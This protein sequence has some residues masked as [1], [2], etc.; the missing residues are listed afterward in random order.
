MRLRSSRT[1]W[2]GDRRGRLLAAA[3]VTAVIAYVGWKIGESPSQALQFGF[4]GLSVGAIYALLA[5]GFTIVYSTVWFFDLYYGASAAIGAYGVFYLRSKD[6]LSGLHSVHNAYV[7][8]LFASVVAGVVAW[9]LYE[10]LYRRLSHRYN[11]EVLLAA[12]GIVSAA[13]GCYTLAVLH[14]TE[15]LNVVLSPA[16]GCAAALA[17]AWLVFKGLERVVGGAGRRIVVGVAAVMGLAVGAF[18]ALYVVGEPGTRLYLSWVL[19]CLLA[20]VVG[21]A[22][23]RGLYAHMRERARSPLVMLVATLGILLA[24]S[25]AIVLVFGSPARPLPDV[26]GSQPREIW[27][28]TI[29]DFN[30]FT[31]GVAIVAFLGLLF[32]LKRTSLGRA[33]RAIGDDEEVSKVVGI[34]TTVVI[35]I[36]FFIGAVYAAL[37]GVLSGHD[38]AIQPRM[39]LLLL[40]KGWIASVVGGI[41]NLYGAAIGGLA[42]GMVEQFGIWDL[43]GEWRDVI[44]F[45]LL[46]L[47]LSFWPRGLLPRR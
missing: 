46:I 34:N 15:N 35:S 47:F 3:L 38:T 42:L 26:F 28:G 8:V 25:A 31:V 21:L 27:G 19:S 1:F 43:A 39:G 12:G 11:R 23:Y 16:V 29:K 13:A 9:I 41:G 33:I 44:S 40:L 5:M 4:N 30:L 18:A 6:A 22:L 36:V 7:N 32:L 37:A 24:I 14:Y 17:T 10:T 2:S 45:V 20:G